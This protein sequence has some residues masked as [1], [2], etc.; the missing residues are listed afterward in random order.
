MN[1]D[2]GKNRKTAGRRKKIQRRR[3]AIS[4]KTAIILASVLTVT[5]TLAAVFIYLLVVPGQG[6]DTPMEEVRA[7]E[8]RKQETVPGEPEGNLGSAVIDHIITAGDAVDE[9]YRSRPESHEITKALP[10][11]R[12]ARL[13]RTPAGLL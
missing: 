1:K 3:G 9:A 2:T 6:E 13:I 5:V 12:P 10:P 11:S 8:T 7:P 4:R